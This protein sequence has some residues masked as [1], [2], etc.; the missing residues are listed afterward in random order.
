MKKIIVVLLVL[1]LLPS[2][3][4]GFLSAFSDQNHTVRSVIKVYDQVFTPSILDGISVSATQIN[5][6][7]L[8]ENGYIQSINNQKMIHDTRIWTPTQYNSGDVISNRLTVKLGDT[9]WQISKGYYGNGNNWN[10]ILQKNFNIIGYLPNH[11]HSKIIV[12]QV[13][14]L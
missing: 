2:F 10:V 12:G 4:V 5:S 1:S 11:S 14:T 8:T 7:D 13:L 9:L 3:Y 6:S